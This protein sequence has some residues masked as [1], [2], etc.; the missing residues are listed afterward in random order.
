MKQ[1]K[2]IIKRNKSP[3]EN[4]S[5]SPQKKIQLLSKNINNYINEVE[6]ENNNDNIFENLNKLKLY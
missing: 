6:E 5:T 2:T 3:K 4:I 1:L